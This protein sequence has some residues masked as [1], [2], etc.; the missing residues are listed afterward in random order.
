MYVQIHT[1]NLETF[2]SLETPEVFITQQL[3][4][5]SIKYTTLNWLIHYYYLKFIKK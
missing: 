1:Q 5:A 4:K 3:S 2:S